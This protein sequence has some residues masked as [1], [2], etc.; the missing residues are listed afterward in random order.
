MRTVL[1]AHSMDEIMVAP[2]NTSTESSTEYLLFF[3]IYIYIY[4]ISCEFFYFLRSTNYVTL[5]TAQL[6]VMATHMVLSRLYPVFVVKYSNL[7]SWL[8]ILSI[9]MEAGLGLPDIDS[10]NMIEKI[11]E[12]NNLGYKQLVSQTR[13]DSVLINVFFINLFSW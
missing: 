12:R 3:L 6:I 13:H 10:W 5:V 7:L 4:L 11:A 9:I 8:F 2:T 1:K